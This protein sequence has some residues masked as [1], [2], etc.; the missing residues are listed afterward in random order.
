M[1]VT[2]KV[3]IA[4]FNVRLDPVTRQVH[5]GGYAIPMKRIGG[6]LALDFVNTVKG[7]TSPDRLPRGRDYR[8][9]VVG[10]Y[11]TSQ[12]DVLQWATATTSR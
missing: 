4:G 7:R 1:Q 11:L 10:D 5:L 8:D 2:F 6:H 9:V 3:T 12:K